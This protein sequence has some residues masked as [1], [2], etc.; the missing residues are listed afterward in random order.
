ML[1]SEARGRK[2]VGLATAETVAT[3]S[4][5]VVGPSPARITA[6]RLKGH[7]HR[8]VLRWEAIEAFGADAVTVRSVGQIQ[9][10]KETDD[11][12]VG[13]QHDPMGKT[14]LTEEGRIL[15]TVVDVSFDHASGRLERLLTPGVEI[16]AER[17]LGVGTNAVVVAT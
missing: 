9:T 16:E 1:F 5:L 10:A 8:D 14:V 6:F 13:V 11:E 15:G 4:T 12:R 17:L 7:G 2:V 3:V